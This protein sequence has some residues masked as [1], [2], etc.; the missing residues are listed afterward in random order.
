MVWDKEEQENAF[1]SL[2]RVLGDYLTLL[3]NTVF[4]PLHWAPEKAPTCV[5]QHLR[6]GIYVIHQTL[7]TS[8]GTFLT[9]VH[10]YFVS[11][12]GELEMICIHRFTAQEFGPDTLIIIQCHVKHFIGCHG[13]LQ[14]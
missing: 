14:I 4:Q 10:A 6:F 1:E 5:F 11:V 7:D 8:E 13:F 9:D 3:P 12:H 2:V